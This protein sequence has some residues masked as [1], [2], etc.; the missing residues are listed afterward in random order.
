MSLLDTFTGGKSSDASDAL[1]RAEGYFGGLRTPSASELMLPKLKEYVEAGLMTPEEA[2]AYMQ[3][4]NA[5]ADENIDQNGTAAQVQALNAL[6]RVSDAGPEGTPMQQAQMENSLEQARTADQGEIG[7]IEQSMAARG[8]PRALIQAA[9]ASQ[10]QGQNAQQAHSDAVNA[11]GATYQNALAALAQKGNLGGQLQGQQNAQANQV[12]SAQNAMQQFNASNQQANSNANANRA[13]DV[14][15]ANMNNK[16]TVANNNVGLANERTQ[17]NVQV[18]QQVFNNQLN[19]ASGQAGA[20][21]NVAKLD[22]QQGQQN[23]GLWGGIINTG[24]SFIPKPT[25]AAPQYAHGGVVQDDNAYCASDG[26]MVPGEANFP[27]DTEANDTVPIQASPGEAVIPR[28][29][30]AQNPEVVESLIDGNNGG[31]SEV[32]DY[33]DAVTLLKALKAMRVGGI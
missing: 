21:S 2:Q 29:S 14:N 23:A 8:I 18:P 3:N 16:Q 19:K 4:S 5:F 25:A 6:S 9:M 27:G 7:A 12:A 32:V 1:N 11:Q 31:Q 24:T 28:S 13:Q 30:V 26:M 15:M 20:A 17:Y 22:Q 33:Q 10:V